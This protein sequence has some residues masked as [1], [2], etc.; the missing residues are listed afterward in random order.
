MGVALECYLLRHGVMSEEEPEA[1]DWLGENI[2][3]GIGNDLSVHV[4]IARSISNTPD[5]MT[6]ERS[7][8]SEHERTY[9][10]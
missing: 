6:C 2:K 10:G 5:A 3:D 8:R 4:D 1:K 7:A 9:T